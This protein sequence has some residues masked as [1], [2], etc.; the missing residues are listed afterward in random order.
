[1]WR[2]AE[3]NVRLPLE[4]GGRKAKAQI[5]DNSEDPRELLELVGL[6]DRTEAYP[7]ELSG[8]M[9]QRVAIARALVTR[10]KVLLMDEPFGAL[11]EIT[12]EA[13]NDEL[14]RIWRE[15]GTTVVFVTHSIAESV[16]LSERIAV[17]TAHPGSLAGII[18]VNLPEREQGIQ[19]S[20]EFV[21]I[22]SRAR[23]LLHG[24]SI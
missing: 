20:P 1:P 18:E 13:M 12:R 24:G 5:S 4:V 10:P 14:L 16:Y 23:K 3:E 15:T 17:L 11:D 2:T 21:E 22:A 8:G 19:D 9:R 7:R 6:G